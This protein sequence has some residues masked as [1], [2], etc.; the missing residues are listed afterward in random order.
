MRLALINTAGIHISLGHMDNRSNLQHRVHRW[1]HGRERH[2]YQQDRHQDFL[3]ADINPLLSL[4]VFLTNLR[5][6]SPRKIKL[7]PQLACPR[8]GKWRERAS[9]EDS[10]IGS[11]L[12]FIAEINLFPLDYSL[13]DCHHFPLATLLN[14]SENRHNGSFGSSQYIAIATATTEGLA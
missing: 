1:L 11:T 8:M 2:E 7:R 9:R 5:Y 10:C 13:F 4:Q 3:L 6:F 12:G 14:K